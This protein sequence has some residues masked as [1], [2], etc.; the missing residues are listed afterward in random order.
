MVHRQ[1]WVTLAALGEIF[2]SVGCW[3]KTL[4]GVL[5]VPEAVML[6]GFTILLGG[7]VAAPLSQVRCKGFRVKTQ[8]SSLVM[9]VLVSK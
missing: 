5:P 7:A 6:L 4:P 2:G 1:Q 8:S 3:V 9:A